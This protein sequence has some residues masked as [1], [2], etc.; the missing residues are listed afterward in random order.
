MSLPPE[1]DRIR[2]KTPEKS[3][4]NEKLCEKNARLRLSQEGLYDRSDRVQ[5]ER[6]CLSSERLNHN[7]SDKNDDRKYQSIFVNDQNRNNLIDVDLVSK[8]KSLSSSNFKND[9][10]KERS[11]RSQENLNL[12]HQQKSKNSP[13][14][15]EQKEKF[16]QEIKDKANGINE[17]HFK[18]VKND[19]DKFQK[20]PIL[21]D[22]KEK[23]STA[24][25]RRNVTNFLAAKNIPENFSPGPQ[26]V[27]ERDLNSVPLRSCEV[28]VF[29]GSQFGNGNFGQKIDDLDVKHEEYFHSTR[30]STD[31]LYE[32]GK[33]DGK[34]KAEQSGSRGNSDSKC[35]RSD[36]KPDNLNR[37]RAE[38]HVE[39][40]YENVEVQ[41]SPRNLQ[42]YEN[43]VREKIL[44]VKKEQKS[45]EKGYSGVKKDSS[46]DLKADDSV[47][48]IPSDF[49]NTSQKNLVVKPLGSNVR[50][51]NTNNSRHSTRTTGKN[52]SNLRS[53][54]GSSP[55]QSTVFSDG[56]FQSKQFDISS[57][58]D[59]GKLAGLVAFNK[60]GPQVNKQLKNLTS[61]KVVTSRQ[62]NGMSTSNS[63]SRSQRLPHRH[64][65]EQELRLLQV[66][67]CRFS[68]FLFNQSRIMTFLCCAE[69]TGCREFQ[70][71]N[72]VFGSC[73]HVRYLKQFTRAY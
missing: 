13:T 25:P 44:Y 19:S 53:G 30:E 59:R 11:F 64:V 9:Q 32:V 48:L 24:V 58:K 67:F 16:L 69:A 29:V 51:L 34:V 5:N 42:N 38:T 7:F 22:I 70:R 57:G 10:I 1:P 45:P 50:T 4:S 6:L 54:G 41:G 56:N 52:H 36:A 14:F 31:S 37:T 63:G 66:S 27:P 17:K 47:I 40:N 18:N 15:Q 68:C 72:S 60:S 23:K 62:G 73:F 49:E 33:E 8:E 3:L 43:E 28:D 61:A 35:N 2:L 20:S 39:N 65:S 21:K 46:P 26:L 71:R 55:D 12:K